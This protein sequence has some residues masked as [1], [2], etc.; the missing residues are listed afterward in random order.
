MIYFK[1]E[2]DV[3]PTNARKLNIVQIIIES[4][5]FL[6]FVRT[7]TLTFSFPTLLKKAGDVNSTY[8]LKVKFGLVYSFKAT[9]LLVVTYSYLAHFLSPSSKNEKNPL[10]KS[11]NIFL[12]FRKWNMELSHSNIKKFLIFS[13][14]L[15]KLRVC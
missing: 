15:S 8:K 12:Y 7:L 6:Q 14:I 2:S 11:S 1:R 9:S 13:F 4:M 3:W 5:K 10:Y